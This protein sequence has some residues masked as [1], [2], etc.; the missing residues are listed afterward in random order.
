MED[1][2]FSSGITLKEQEIHIVMDLCWNFVLGYLT[3]FG[4]FYWMSFESRTLSIAVDMFSNSLNFTLMDL[5][6]KDENSS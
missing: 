2:D 5:C 3:G 4:E 1:G 6:T